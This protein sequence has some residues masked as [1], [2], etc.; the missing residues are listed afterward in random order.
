MVLAGMKET[1][2]DK[3]KLNLDRLKVSK[4]DF[5]EPKVMVPSVMLFLTVFTFGTVLTLGPNISDR[6][7]LPSRGIYI[8]SYVVASLL[9]RITAGKLSDIYGRVAVL[10]IAVPV[11]TAAAL[12]MGTADSQVQFIIASILLGLGI[13]MSSPAIYALT[14]DLS[15]EKYR[16]R[17]IATMY[18]FLEAGIGMGA[19]VSGYLYSLNNNNTLIPFA[20]SA[21]LSASAFLYLILSKR[22]Q[23]ESQAN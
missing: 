2:K 7:L 11:I 17:G 15:D 20:L 16:G 1:L 21:S 12:L 10:R 4:N 5:Y 14:I 22:K 9:V 3:K 23:I 8:F 18:I 19:L 13:G 6:L